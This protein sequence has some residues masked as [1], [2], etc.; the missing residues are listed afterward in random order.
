LYLKNTKNLYFSVQ[1][2]PADSAATGCC[3]A[4][5]LFRSFQSLLFLSI[6]PAFHRKNDAAV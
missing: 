3:P 6:V 5:L 2:N 4:A 1:K